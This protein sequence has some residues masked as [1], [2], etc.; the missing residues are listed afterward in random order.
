MPKYKA[1][2]TDTFSGEANYS[3]VRRYEF[4]AVSMRGAVQMLAHAYGSGWR[5]AYDDGDSARFD[6]RGACV[7]AFISVADEA[8][9]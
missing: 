7:C 2:V 9:E 4:R 8:T 1:E 3:W 6:L 5:A